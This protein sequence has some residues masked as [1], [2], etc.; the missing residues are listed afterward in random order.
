MLESW[1]L[2]LNEENRAHLSEDQLHS[3]RERSFKALEPIVN[4][5][6]MRK[7]WLRF[8][9]AA[10]L[11]F[12][13][14]ASVYLLKRDRSPV[15][16]EELAQHATPRPGNDIGP[17]QEGATLT[18][19]NRKKIRLTDAAT[20]KLA[21]EA[22]ISISKTA[23]GQVVYNVIAPVDGG[24]AVMNTISTARGETYRITLPDKSNVWL[25]AASSLTYSTRLQ[26]NGERR[27]ILSGEAYFEVFKDKAHPFV[28]QTDQQEVKVLG[29]HFNVN[30]YPDEPSTRTTLLEGAVQINNKVILKPGEQSILTGKRL[31]VE[32]ADVSEAIAWKSG[33]FK[34]NDDENI[35]S[36]MR[37][38]GRWYNVD[39]EFVGDMKA[40]N[41]TGKIS[42][43]KNIS[44]LLQT[45]EQ[46]GM[47][48]FR[49]DGRKVI[50][51]AQ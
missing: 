3:A 47:V 21:E 49:I 40:V 48:K 32:G 6:N 46:T 24:A 17:G 2:Q 7:V 37:R 34:F 35:T 51:S 23:N 43:Q 42:R 38:V 15:V 18:L 19:A 33:L 20:G 14:G 39:V 5:E 44:V 36:I 28:V 1:Y 50:V 27:V 10:T 8:A 22:G 4:K 29:T 26:E 41:F 25:N 9:A 13:V 12:A 16:P 11:L 30:A 45:M 31:R